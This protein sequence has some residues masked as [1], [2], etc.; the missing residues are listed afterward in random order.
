MHL[1]SQSFA[2]LATEDVVAVFGQF[3]G[4]EPRHVLH[5]SEDRHVH[6]LV[7]VHIDTLASV[8]ECHC[9]WGAD[10]DGASDGEGLQQG[11]VDVARARRGVEDEVV[12]IAPVGIGDELFQGV[13]RHASAPE[14]SGV[15]RYEEADGEELHT[16]LLDGLDELS[17]VALYGVGTGVLY[18]EHLRHRRTED[19]GVE[20][21]HLVTQSGERD[22]E[23]GRDGRLA[24]AA[25]SG[26]H[27]D[28]VLHAR[29][30]L[31]HLGTGLRLKLGGDGDLHLGGIVLA[32]QLSAA[33][34][35]GSLGSLHS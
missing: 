16:I 24:H 31:T 5:E 25:F 29:E 9:L 13:R 14:G 17:T 6:L 1:L 15:W 12:E 20:Q 11:E 19:I 8:G 33:V 35:D 18:V 4:R 32:G 26:A 28:D 21:S 7:L 3:G 34:F 30:H 10:D 27:G 22:G 23:V 2:T